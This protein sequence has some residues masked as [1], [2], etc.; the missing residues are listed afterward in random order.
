MAI[1]PSLKSCPVCFLI[2][3]LSLVSHAQ[4]N[5]LYPPV[6]SQ[7]FNYQSLVN[8]SA[9]GRYDK[10]SMLAGERLNAGY[11]SRIRTFLAI[12]EYARKK[13]EGSGHGFGLIFMN[14]KEGS[15][16][17]F[18]RMYAQYAY[19]LALSENWKISGGVSLGLL[20]L[21]VDP[22]PTSQGVS[23]YAPDGSIGFL[24]YR[25]KEQIG[26]SSSQI[27]NR[28]IE[29]LSQPLPIK[30]YYK[31]LYS[32]KM[33]LT[34]HTS[35]T[36]WF[37]YTMKKE[38]S[39]LDITGSFL[40]DDLFFLG[41]SYQLQRGTVYFLGIRDFSFLEGLTDLTVS[42]SLPWPSINL[43]NIQTF[44]IVLAYKLK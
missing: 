15:L 38:R 43:G 30:R 31:F 1:I 17:S 39:E 34:P 5:F 13:D 18:N 20:N 35:F 25:D 6:F 29:L 23:S 41:L 40:I 27:F 22:T 36:P 12:G 19:H 14:H 2:I 10:L 4:N 28:S 8:P 9:T 26:V 33:E 24:F 3:L 21:S 7:F 44:E 42:Y 37:F 16:F 32:R 11:F